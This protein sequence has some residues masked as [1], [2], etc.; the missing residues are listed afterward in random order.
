MYVSSTLTHSDI[1]LKGDS[2]NF[3][4]TSSEIIFQ[5]TESHKSHLFHFYENYR[6][7]GRICNI[8]DPL[9]LG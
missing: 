8:K 6:G 9:L 3:N 4:Y 1:V 5:K 2:L 7:D